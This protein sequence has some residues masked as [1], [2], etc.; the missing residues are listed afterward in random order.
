MSSPTLLLSRVLLPPIAVDPATQLHCSTHCCW[1]STC[2]RIAFWGIAASICFMTTP[3]RI[4]SQTSDLKFER[5][6]TEQGLSQDIVSSI[7]QDGEGFM[8]FATE[9]GLNRY[10]GYSIKV[11]KH[12][13]R[14]SAS[15]PSNSV[16]FLFVDRKGSLWIFTPSAI[17]LYLPDR[18]AFSNISINGAAYTACEDDQGNIWVGTANGLSK[19]HGRDAT[20]TPRSLEEGDSAVY[21]LNKS[22]SG[23]LWLV[24]E[25]GLFQL[26][27]S[28]AMRVRSKYVEESDAVMVIFGV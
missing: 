21:S 17:S 13:P 28:T 25:A 12:N 22:G 9:N 11:Y 24:T 5:I 16:R 15:I 19:F 23:M 8:W 26:D 6:S 18:D 20:L 7:V 10:D 3:E 2:S 1:L 4:L 27:P 14:D